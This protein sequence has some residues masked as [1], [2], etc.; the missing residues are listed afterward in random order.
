MYTPALR[1]SAFAIVHNGV[2]RLIITAVTGVNS[3]KLELRLRNFR[4]SQSV[5]RVPE[6]EIRH[7]DFSWEDDTLLRAIMALVRDNALA[8]LREH[9]AM[10]TAMRDV[11]EFTHPRV[12]KITVDHM[13]RRLGRT[14]K[15]IV[16]LCRAPNRDRERENTIIREMIGSGCLVFMDKTRTAGNDVLR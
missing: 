6:R 5:W 14:R 11:P 2:P 13:L 16:R 15:V 8:L 7:E 4:V 3:A 9:S 12:S 1:H 10:M